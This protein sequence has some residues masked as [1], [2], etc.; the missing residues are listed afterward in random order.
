MLQPKK[1]ND[2]A[3]SDSS[4]D[5]KILSCSIND[6]EEIIEGIIGDPDNKRLKDTMKVFDNFK[7]K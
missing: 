3:A 4:E 6:E 5:E 7:K 1:I 2:A